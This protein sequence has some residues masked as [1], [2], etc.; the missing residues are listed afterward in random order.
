MRRKR[1]PPVFVWL[2]VSCMQALHAAENSGETGAAAADILSLI[3]LGIVILFLAAGFCAL[4]VIVQALR[5][6]VTR[7]MS[8]I[9][10]HSPG[11]SLLYGVL[12]TTIFLLTLS[13]IKALPGNLANVLVLLVLVPY[14]TMLIVGTAGVAQA[15]GAKVLTGAQ[16]P[17]QCSDTWAAASGASIL[18]LVNLFP[19]VGWA[20]FIASTL[21]GLG[22]LT[23][24]ALARKTMPELTR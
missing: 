19:F 14:V 12:V 15:L 17:K 16:S 13:I 18:A 4:C 7:D 23:R 21:V 22:A 8:V 11:R 24:N 10:S 2:A 3:Y 6:R 5:A 9:V 20:V 1:T